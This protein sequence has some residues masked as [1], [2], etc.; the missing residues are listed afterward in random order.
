MILYGIVILGIGLGTLIGVIATATGLHRRFGLPYALLTVG[1]ITFIGA[2]LAQVIIVQVL[3]HTLFAVLPA[4]FVGLI[5]GFT[6]EIARLL[7]FQYLARS[8]VTRPQALLIGIGHGAPWAA[9]TAL[10]IAGVGLSLVGQT[11]DP[12]DDLGAVLRDACAGALTGLLPLVMHM[13]LSWVV[14]QVFLRGEIYWLFVAFFAHAVVEIMA[15]LLGG[16]EDW[17]VVAWRALVAVISAAVII[18]VHPPAT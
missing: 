9:Y 15:R 7:G 10:L 6:Q 4:L 13:A 2:W 5:A 18:R 1:M 12:P 8:T 11:G 16:G 3:D 17:S 14:L